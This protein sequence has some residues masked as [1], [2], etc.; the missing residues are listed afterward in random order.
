M[1]LWIGAILCFLAYGIRSATEEEPPNDDV[2]CVVT[3]PLSPPVVLPAR[4]YPVLFHSGS[5]CRVPACGCQQ[6]R[7][8]SAR[9][10][11]H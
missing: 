5:F 11:S 4:V 1:L 2:S 9:C 6:L 8:V 3:V 7:K 10:G